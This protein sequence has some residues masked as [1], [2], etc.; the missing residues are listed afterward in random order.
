MLS[1]KEL[2]KALSVSAKTIYGL[3]DENAIPYYRIGK[4]RGTLRFD[5]DEVKN[6]LQAVQEDMPRQRCVRSKHLNC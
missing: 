5:L 4:G 1:V 6:A 3:C 2:A